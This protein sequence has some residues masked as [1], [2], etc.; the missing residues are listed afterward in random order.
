MR[1]EHAVAQPV[2]VDNA[3][4]ATVAD[5]ARVDLGE[6]FGPHVNL[7]YLTDEGSSFE[8]E[9]WGIANWDSHFAVSSPS[10]LRIPNTLAFTHNDGTAAFDWNSAAA[11][12]MG[13]EAQFHSAEVNLAYRV[14]KG[15]SDPLHYH[16]IPSAEVLFGVRYIELDELFEISSANVANTVLASQYSIATRNQLFG[17]Q[18]G[19]RF[20]QCFGCRIVELETKFGV[21]N[22]TAKQT[23]G[24]TDDAGTVLVRNP[25]IFT[26]ELPVTAFSAEANLM[27]YRCI[28]KV[29]SFR[30][31][32]NML[33]LSNVARAP[34]QLDFTSNPGS[35]SAAAVPQRGPDPRGERGI[36]SEVVR[37]GAWSVG[38]E[39]ENVKCKM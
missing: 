2:I 35:G 33:W 16:D 17:F 5:A 6:G 13:Y 34:D 12:E 11:M 28:D 25:A 19:G 31:G 26:N 9:Y 27:I 23:T 1:L 3:T 38:R 24:M 10:L 4:G 32:Y 18:S 39:G 21:Y 15:A 36:G 14:D 29:W 37:G 30:Y 8:V 7:A 20:R 22:N